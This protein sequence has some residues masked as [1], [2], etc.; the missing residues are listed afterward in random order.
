MSNTPSPDT[1]VR[2]PAPT[3]Y[4]RVYRLE[5]EEASPS[6]NVLK[7]MHFQVYKKTREFWRIQVL[8]ALGRQPR[9]PPIERSWLFVERHCAGGGLDWDNAYGG[10]K[11]LLDCLVS[12]S[13]RNPSGL[14]LIV[15][16][17]PKHM[18]VPPLMLQKDAPRGKSVTIV[19]IYDLNRS[20]RNE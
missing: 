6:N 14:G 13:T 20:L 7:G 16:D 18:P 5:L 1:F 11:P 3:D 15:D 2:W 12:P 10:L 17:S 19:E 4:E 8:K 9:L